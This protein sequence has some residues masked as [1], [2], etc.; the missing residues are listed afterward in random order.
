MGKLD[1]QFNYIMTGIL[2]IKQKKKNFNRMP[3]NTQSKPKPVF[4]ILRGSNIL[5][6]SV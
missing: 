5:I 6:T 4:K 2:Q 1:A 3:S